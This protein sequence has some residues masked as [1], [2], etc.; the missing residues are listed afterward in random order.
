MPQAGCILWVHFFKTLRMFKGFSVFICVSE[1]IIIEHSSDNFSTSLALL[2]HSLRWWWFIAVIISWAVFP[3][4]ICVHA[5]CLCAS[6][7]YTNHASFYLLH[8]IWFSFAENCVNSISL[9]SIKS[10]LISLLS[11]STI[12]LTCISKYT[13]IN[14]NTYPKLLLHWLFMG[15]ICGTLL[16]KATV[17]IILLTINCLL[18][19]TQRPVPIR[20]HQRKQQ[21]HQIFNIISHQLSFLFTGKISFPLS[22]MSG[23]GTRYLK[24]T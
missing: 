12:L 18:L 20:L 16:S 9:S 24:Q 3:Y 5:S 11:N 21:K 4:C 17:I 23:S 15:I 10:T 1:L 14:N 8:F 22:S 13:H 6:I 19:F 2:T 7:I